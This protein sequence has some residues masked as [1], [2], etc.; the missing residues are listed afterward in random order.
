MTNLSSRDIWREAKP[1]FK[2]KKP[3]CFTLLTF[4]LIFAQLAGRKQ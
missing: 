2:I 3:Q 1:V 4:K